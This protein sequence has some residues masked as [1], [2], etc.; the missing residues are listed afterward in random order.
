MGERSP[1]LVKVGTCRESSIC[2]RWTIIRLVHFV[3]VMMVTIQTAA[4]WLPLL[5]PLPLPPAFQKCS[6]SLYEDKPAGVG[7]VFLMVE[8]VLVVVVVD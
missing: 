1:S 3:H 2:N 8:V 7:T 5:L 6:S 4:L